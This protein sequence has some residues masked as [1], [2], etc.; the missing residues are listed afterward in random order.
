M[1]LKIQS[2]SLLIQRLNEYLKVADKTMVQ[3]LG[4]VEDKRTFNNLAFMISKL[5]NQLTTY[6]NLFTRNFYVIFN[7]YMVQPLQHGKKFTLGFK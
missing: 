3:V 1:W 5:C 6:F 4:L 7:F 2:F